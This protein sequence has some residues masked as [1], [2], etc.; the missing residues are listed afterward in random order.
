[1]VAAAHDYVKKRPWQAVQRVGASSLQT[2]PDSTVDVGQATAGN[3]I[4]QGMG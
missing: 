4:L 2:G 1:M 3:A